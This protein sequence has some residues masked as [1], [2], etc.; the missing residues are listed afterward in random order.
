LFVLGSFWLQR[1]ACRHGR[2]QADN[3]HGEAGTALVSQPSALRRI[4]STSGNFLLKK[5][6]KNCPMWFGPFIS[7]K[8]KVTGNT[9]KNHKNPK[10]YSSCEIAE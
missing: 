7:E 2:G 6:I 9:S 1:P 4:I 8:L 3:G 10:W 5:I